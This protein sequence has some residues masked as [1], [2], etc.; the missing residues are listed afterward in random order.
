MSEND[1]KVTIIIPTLNEIEGM[2]WF[3]PRLKKEWYD[4]LIVVDGHSSDG[5]VEYCRMNNYPLVFQTGKRLSNAYDNAF[6]R[7]TKDIIV[8]VTPDGSS[9]PELIPELIAKI[10][11]GYDMVIASRYLGEAK[12]LDDD[13]FTGFGNRMFTGMI[14]LLFGGR[15]T[16]SLVAF[17]AYRRNA[18]NRM[19]LYGQDKQF[20]L[21]KKFPD[22]NSWETASSIRAAKFK[23]KV[24][25]IPGDEPKRIGGVRKLSI[26]KNG[27]GTLFQIIHEFITGCSFLNG[28]SGDKEQGGKR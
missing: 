13:M 8:T 12:S 26:V 7:S 27:S 3:M 16:D 15:Y 6:S 14:N 19:V 10:R 21:K 9:L 2:K 23:L 4:E 24:F 11:E 28:G 20:W 1:L 5:T 17:R 18:V 25:E 22:M